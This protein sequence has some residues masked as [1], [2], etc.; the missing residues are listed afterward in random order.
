[1]AFNVEI[2]LKI[3]GALS[4]QFREISSEFFRMREVALSRVP[5]SGLSCEN[6]LF[7]CWNQEVA[8]IHKFLDTWDF[9]PILWTVQH[10]LILGFYLE[11][12]QDNFIA[13]I[14]NWKMAL[15]LISTFLRQLY[16]NVSSF[17]K[18]QNLPVWKQW[19]H[20]RKF[21][22]REQQFLIFEGVA[23]VFLYTV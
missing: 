9:L 20:T 3:K 11:V 19:S 22:W 5:V 18:V 23:N 14:F 17:W 21:S 1:M 15:L 4:S 8:K 6:S 7:I 12:S 2:S 10:K 13:Q 16:R